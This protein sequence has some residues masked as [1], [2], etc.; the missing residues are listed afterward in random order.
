MKLEKTSSTD[1]ILKLIAIQNNFFEIN[2]NYSVC[3]DSLFKW[4]VHQGND[5]K[6]IINC[7]LKTANK[8][9]YSFKDYQDCKIS[10]SLKHPFKFLDAWWRVS[11]YMFMNNWDILDT[12]AFGEPTL[13]LILDP[14]LQN[15][16][17]KYNKK[18]SY[19]KLL[20]NITSK[21]VGPALDHVIKD[22]S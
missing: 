16:P 12:Y 7:S 11:V 18:L 3:H 9:Y 17:S 10:A 13:D 5:I 2:K 22:K 20:L 1:F 14:P 15:I 4:I 6:E 21:W 8:D 19:R